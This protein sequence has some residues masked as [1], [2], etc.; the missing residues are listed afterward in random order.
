[1]EK[2]EKIKLPEPI[3]IKKIHSKLD[4]FSTKNTTIRR[5]KGNEILKTFFLLYLFNKYKSNCLITFQGDFYNRG[6]GLWLQTDILDKELYESEL[7]NVS[8]QLVKCIVRGVSS[9][10]IPLYL[11]VHD[12]AHANLLIYRKNGN[13]IEH[14]EPHGAHIIIAD[15]HEIKLINTRLNEFI[16]ILNKQLKKKDKPPVKLIPSNEVCPVIKGLQAIEVDSSI[17]KLPIEGG[18]YC[19]AWSLFFAELVLKNPTIPSNELLNIILNKLDKYTKQEQ[20]DYLRK[21][22]TGYINMIYDKI[23]KYFYFVTGTHGKIDNIMELFSE[24]DKDLLFDFETIITIQTALLNKP[25]LTKKKYLENLKTKKM[26]TTDKHDIDLI[27]KQIYILNRMESISFTPSSLSNSNSKTKKP[28]KSGKLAKTKKNRDCPEGSKINPKT[29]RCNK[30]KVYPPC[31][32]TRDP[33]TH[34]CKRIE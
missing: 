28:K 15:D 33:I 21:V 25:H 32:P 19:A 30:I 14:F 8:T 20:A 17:K 10:V 3:H 26:S 4:L 7:K 27:N 6:L 13:T 24:H 5:W 18:G 16:D 12:D 34:R 11:E 23:E 22:I 31:P 1:M 2:E 29:G 9:I